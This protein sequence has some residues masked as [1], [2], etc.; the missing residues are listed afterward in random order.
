MDKDSIESPSEVPDPLSTGTHISEPT[1]LVDYSFGR[2]QVKIRLTLSGRF[3]GIEAI[4]LAKEFLSRQQRAAMQEYQDV[5]KFY[6]DED[7]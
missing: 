5:E 3:V 4:S 6:V 2:Y 1:T 7:E